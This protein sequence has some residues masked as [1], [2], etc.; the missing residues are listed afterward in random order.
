MV[1][2][3]SG[4]RASNR[5][6]HAEARSA[7]RGWGGGGVGWRIRSGGSDALRYGMR[8]AEIGGE[9][10]Q[11]VHD[12]IKCTSLQGACMGCAGRYR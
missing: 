12:H 5:H 10:R 1:E 9:S 11:W 7:G 8:Q 3:P 2:V 4:M 6:E